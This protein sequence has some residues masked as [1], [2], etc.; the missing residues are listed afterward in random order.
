MINPINNWTSVKY[1]DNQTLLREPWL[2]IYN[3]L[4]WDVWELFLGFPSKFLPGLQKFYHG[5]S[6]GIPLRIP[7]EGFPE[8]L[9]QCLAEFWWSF[10]KLSKVP[11]EISLSSILSFPFFFWKSCEISTEALP[12]IFFLRVFQKLSWSCTRDFV[13][14]FSRD[15][16]SRC[17]DFLLKFP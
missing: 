4:F 6:A 3:C 7:T 12:R 15:F 5:V 13:R 14:S 2:I 17:S 11:L 8:M 9:Q 10:L 16:S 1:I